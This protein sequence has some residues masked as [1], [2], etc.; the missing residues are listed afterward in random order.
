M[1]DW[2]MLRRHLAC[3]ISFRAS[4]DKVVQEEELEGSLESSEVFPANNKVQHKRQE[5]C[6]RDCDATCL[7]QARE[8]PS[9]SCSCLHLS[10]LGF[11]GP[12]L[13]SCSWP[14]AY[15]ALCP[16]ATHSEETIRKDGFIDADCYDD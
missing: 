15:W 1:Y 9:A 11:S 8:S 14:W 12:H 2:N 16:W 4:T 7:P 13:R 10:S 5:R 6:D 3:T